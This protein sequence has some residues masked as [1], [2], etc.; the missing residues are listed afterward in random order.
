MRWM[1]LL[2]AVITTGCTQTTT[3]PESGPGINTSRLLQGHPSLTE[4]RQGQRITG[5]DL[6]IVSEEMRS[7]LD[8]VGIGN[9]PINRLNAV[10]KDLKEKEFRLHYD[11]NQTA[12]AAQAFSQR[13]GNCVSFAAMIVSMARYLG[14]EAR[15]NQATIP[16]RQQL[17]T[18]SAEAGYVQN[19]RHI[20]A[21]VISDNK[22]YVIEEDFRIFAGKLLSQLSDREAYAI[23]LN[24][25]AMEAM[26]RNAYGDAF[27]Y[28]R[29]AIL[30]DE[31]ASYLWAGLGTVYR[32]NGQ[33]ELAEESYLHALAL[34][35]EDSVARN[36][37]R[38]LR[39]QRAS[40]PDDYALE[41]KPD[42]VQPPI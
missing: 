34:N 26:R 19:I 22:P 31:D 11:L 42:R 2:L 24:N 9:S 6:F 8:R 36:N 37:L 20:N 14:A 4:H 25:L 23:Y 32:R 29:E 21:V 28:S 38:I 18:G 40:G 16:V 30:H 13:R 33:L 41:V 10:L 35:G 15:L 39:R 7:Y 27:H 17:A 1:I 3:T 5:R 12:S